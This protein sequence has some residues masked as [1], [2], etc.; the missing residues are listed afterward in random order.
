MVDLSLQNP[1]NSLRPSDLQRL[2]A[3]LEGALHFDSTMRTLYATDASVAIRNVELLKDVN[4]PG[5]PLV[6]EVNGEQNSLAEYT[7]HSLWD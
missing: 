1:M 3:E 7:F 6:R 2:A 5:T 4:T